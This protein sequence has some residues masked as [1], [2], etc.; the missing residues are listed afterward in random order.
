MKKTLRTFTAL[1]SLTAVSLSSVA[2]AETNDQ[3]VDVFA[4]PATLNSDWDVVKGF[5]I[6][7]GQLHTNNYGYITLKPDV[8]TIG[9][10]YEVMMTLPGSSAIHTQ[11]LIFGFND[12]ASP[13]YTASV[14]RGSWGGLS[15]SKHDYMGGPKTT[16][17]V[18]GEI[19]FDNT[20]TNTMKVV[21]KSNTVELHYAD[22]MIAAEVNFDHDGRQAGVLGYYNGPDYAVDNFVIVTTNGHDF[23]TD[24]ANGLPSELNSFSGT[25]AAGYDPE[26]D[27]TGAKPT[28]GQGVLLAD[29]VQTVGGYRVEMTWSNQRDTWTQNSPRVV[30]GYTDASSPFYSILSKNGTDVKINL[31][32]HTDSSDVAGT[33]IATSY[34]AGNM[35]IVNGDQAMFGADINESGIV[36]FRQDQHSAEPIEVLQQSLVDASFGPIAGVMFVPGEIE[37]PDEAFVR[38]LRISK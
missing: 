12:A 14:K 3:H 21:V 6:E 11:P 10:E 15:I 36:V 31:Y 24:F 29:G 37:S 16:L 28:E 18:S 19:D 33:E 27:V 32:Y 38:L 30:V 5:V 17:S 23:S 7:N 25:W 9:D 26:Y 2:Y 13:F 8:A 35:D 22:N 34:N 20:A 1:C 4:T